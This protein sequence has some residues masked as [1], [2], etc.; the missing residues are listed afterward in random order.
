MCLSSVYVSLT[1]TG[2]KQLKVRHPILD[3]YFTTTAFS[4]NHTFFMIA[5]PVLFWFGFSEIARGYVLN[6]A[7]EKK[8]AF[9]GSVC[10]FKESEAVPYLWMTMGF[11][12]FDW[13]GSHLLLRWAST[14]LDSSR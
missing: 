4:G 9:S 2:F 13:L 14:G 11:D 5:L 3:V 7:I 1:G 12:L 6:H 10:I 8:K